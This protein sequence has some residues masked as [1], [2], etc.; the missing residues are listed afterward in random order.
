[1][2]WRSFIG[3][4]AVGSVLVGAGGVYLM[5]K[6]GTRGVLMP[7]KHFFDSASDRLGDGFITVSGTLTGPE[8][9]LPDN[10]YSIKCFKRLG[11]CDVITYDGVGHNHVGQ[12]NH[13]EWKIVKWEPDLVVVD[14]DPAPDAC[15]RVTLNLLRRSEEAQY[16][17]HPMNET[18]SNCDTVEMRTF[19]WR[20]DDPPYWR[21]ADGRE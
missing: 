11:S 9:G 3:G 20:I 13:E 4:L 17:R 16:I 10:H 7:R 19:R 8:V 21:R 18:G 2:K 5:A 15:S 14:S 12:A 6:E 1:M